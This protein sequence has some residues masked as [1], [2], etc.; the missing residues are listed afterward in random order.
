M[1][2]TP[3]RKGSSSSSGQPTK[4]DVDSETSLMPGFRKH[5]PNK[6]AADLR[7]AL[8]SLAGR[9]ADKPTGFAALKEAAWKAVKEI[10]KLHTVVEGLDI[11]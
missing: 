4:P 8:L 1:T 7:R 2:T 5:R 3:T 9:N 11:D 6:V 10:E